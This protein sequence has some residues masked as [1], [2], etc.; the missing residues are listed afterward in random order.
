M[1]IPGAFGGGELKKPVKYLFVAV[2]AVLAAA[3]MWKIS[4]GGVP[5]AARETRAEA[6]RVGEV[7]RGPIAEEVRLTGE[8]EAMAEVALAPKVSGR[9]IELAVEE[10]DSVAKGAIVALI[11]RDVFEA[12]VKH[13]AATVGVAEAGVKL[14]QADYENACLGYDRTSRLFEQGTVPESSRD[15]AQAAYK[16]AAA[17]VAVSEAELER[18]K[19]ALELTRIDLKESELTAPFDAVVAEK[20]LDVGAI[21]SP[22]KAIVRLVSVDTV[23]VTAGVA[24]RYLADLAPGETVTTVRVDALGGRQF[25]GVLGR[26]SPVLDRQTRTA[27]VEIRIPNPRHDLKPGMYARVTLVTRTAE[28]ALLVPNDA[29]LGR[30]GFHYAFVVEGGRVRRAPVEVGLRSGRFAQ[31]RGEVEP[32][33]VV[34]TSGAGNLFEGAR[35]SIQEPGK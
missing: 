17:R 9:L 15:D 5:E 26:V 22:G 4:G 27:E 10:G 11:D 31:V 12:T 16:G 28:D 2:V 24:E 35:V 21:V 1:S 32:G 6:V 34:V 30:E 20:L 19:A 13:A 3:I 25:D 8:V 29:L 14:A 33:D 18:A 7:V 23:K